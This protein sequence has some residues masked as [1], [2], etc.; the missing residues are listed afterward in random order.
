M[1]GGV[2]FVDWEVKKASLTFDKTDVVYLVTD[3]KLC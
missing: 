2:C 3:I 1:G